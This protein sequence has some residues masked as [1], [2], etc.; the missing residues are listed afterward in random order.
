MLIFP[1]ASNLGAPSKTPTGLGDGFA[2]EIQVR[3]MSGVSEFSSL[4][5]CNMFPAQRHVQN[6]MLQVARTSQ[7][8]VVG[9]AFG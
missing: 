4:L 9:L 7:R 3:K 1:K 6:S 2:H 5:V 8:G